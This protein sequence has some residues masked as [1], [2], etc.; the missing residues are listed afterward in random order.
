MGKTKR[1]DEETF[2]EKVQTLKS[3][4]K[5]Y[6]SEILRLK[7]TIRDL[8][9]QLNEKGL[10]KPKKRDI[11]KKTDS[12]KAVEKRA[13]LRKKLKEEFKGEKK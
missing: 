10:K 7:R 13:A 4:L 12:E 1:A 11:I 5:K 6:K 2:N 3:K 8:T 9:K